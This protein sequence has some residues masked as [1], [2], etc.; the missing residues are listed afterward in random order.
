MSCGWPSGKRAFSSYV[1]C[2]H[3]T[4]IVWWQEYNPYNKER[5]CVPGANTHTDGA[6]DAHLYLGWSARS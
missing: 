1:S 4:F 5:R 3:P 2:S 6:E